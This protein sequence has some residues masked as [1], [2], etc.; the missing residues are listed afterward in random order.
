MTVIINAFTGCLLMFKVK[1]K[2]KFK[3]YIPVTT[4]YEK[5]DNVLRLNETMTI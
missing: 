5:P 4:T 3:N 1:A 2:I